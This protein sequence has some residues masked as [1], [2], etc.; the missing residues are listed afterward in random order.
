MARL[1][2]GILGGVS[3]KIGNVVGGNWK[4]IDYLRVLPAS[5]ANPKTEKQ[6]DQRT[7]FIRVIRFLQPIT[8]FI[9]VGFKAYAV[10]MTAFNA[11]MSYNFNHAITGAFPDYDIDYTKALVSRGSLAGIINPTLSSDAAGE[12]TFG[13]TDN[14]GYDNTLG[15]DKVMVVIYN[16]DK[17]MA[18]TMLDGS[19]RAAGTLT[20]A[21]PDAW[22][23]DEVHC[24]AACSVLESLISSGGKKSISNSTYCGSVT[25]S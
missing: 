8:E 18:V 10:K 4:G 7:K 13:W 15:T 24:F 12:V 25:V 9:R 5:V 14:S 6:V 19:T 16:P 2:K 11:A 3:G 1:G 22:I 21:V 17:E 23:G 20:L